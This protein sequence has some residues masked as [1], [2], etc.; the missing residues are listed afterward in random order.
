MGDVSEAA[1][2]LK[3]SFQREAFANFVPESGLLVMAHGLGVYQMIKA[4]VH[5]YATPQVLVFILGAN[6]Q[7]E[8][9]LLNCFTGG[10]EQLVGHV[11]FKIVSNDTPAKE[12]IEMYLHGGVISIT[13]RVMLIDLLKNRIPCHL[14]TGIMVLEADKVSEFCLVA[15]ILDLYRGRNIEGFVKAFSEKAEALTGG[16]GKVERMC[17]FLKAPKLLL[18][19]RFHATVK[20]DLDD[21]SLDVEEIHVTLTSKMKIIQLG[22][23]EVLETCLN[24]LLRAN[25]SLLD[26]TDLTIESAVTRSFDIQIK[27]QLDPIWHRISLK[28][29]QLI[30]ELRILRILLEYLT[31]FDA[32]SYC[33]FVESLL[34]ADATATSTGGFRSYWLMLDMAQTIIQTAKDRVYIVGG[35]GDL[36]KNVDPMPKWNLLERL[37]KENEGKKI[38]IMVSEEHTR[39]LLVN[40]LAYGYDEWEN[41]RYSKYQQWRR[42]ARNVGRF[43]QGI[44]ST[45]EAVRKK[46]RYLPPR[47]ERPIERRDII[48]TDE[49][50]DIDCSILL[51]E[52]VDMPASD[53]NI[54]IQC[55]SEEADY[56]KI[57]STLR[58]ELVIIYDNDLAFLRAIELHAY[59]SPLLSLIMLVYKESSEE[60]R[61]LL[62]I[63]REK[64]AFEELIKVRSSMAPPVLDEPIQDMDDSA[65]NNK[66]SGTVE[67]IP[68]KII[69]DMRELRSSLPFILHRQAFILE[70]RT[71]QIGDYILTPSICVERKSVADLV[72][73]LN[74]GRL[75]QQVEAMDR[76]YTTPV[77]LIEFDENKPFSLIPGDLR[78]DISISDISSKLCLLLL[79][80]SRLR[81]IWSSSL[82]NT[83]EM[84]REL[85]RDQAEPAENTEETLEEEGDPTARD[86]LCALPGVDASNVYLIMRHVRNMKEL[87]GRS[88]AELCDMIGVENARKMYHFLHTPIKHT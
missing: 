72:S 32:I 66:F 2:L 51:D 30:S 12:R 18:Y 71:I 19:P 17:K 41:D 83:A 47:S 7:Q 39:R 11:P 61:Q 56:D 77:L 27:R 80:F 60:Q 55:Y 21:V 67:A 58:P 38:L 43:D 50:E 26:T 82:A 84:F 22:L 59:S 87:V 81:I 75:Y 33:K 46:R 35:S 14:T 62:G 6:G 25:A 73:S 16:F 36:Q 85:K 74:S 65:L 13:S 4:F 10:E 48:A 31:A 29:K 45:K 23:L 64:E 79:H 76:R 24:E 52:P 54:F 86:L 8:N 70:P 42:N 34:M 78:S 44:S 40:I 15:F 57:L 37:L 69:V 28:S 5:L 1:K 49:I 9:E 63:R 68:R 20:E 3:A 53:P 88:L